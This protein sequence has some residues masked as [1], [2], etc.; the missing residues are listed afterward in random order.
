MIAAS[1]NEGHE[2]V[3]AVHLREHHDR[4][5]DGDRDHDIERSASC[6]VVQVHLEQ[7]D[8]PLRVDCKQ[9]MHLHHLPSA[10]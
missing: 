4:D 3:C 7:V 8:N 9:I 2:V 10:S 6:E 1:A 5:E